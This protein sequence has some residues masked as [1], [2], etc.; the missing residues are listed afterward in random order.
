MLYI[1]KSSQELT[2]QIKSTILLNNTPL[3]VEIMLWRK[4]S[5]NGKLKRVQG[6]DEQSIL[7]VPNIFHKNQKHKVKQDIFGFLI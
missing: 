4:V 1:I 6:F 7:M 3:F 5:I 2:S